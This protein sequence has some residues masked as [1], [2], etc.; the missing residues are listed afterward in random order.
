M[1]ILRLIGSWFLLAALF[2]LVYD[3]TKSMANP[4]QWVIT[5]YY[6]HWNAIHPT[7]LEAARLATETSLHPYVWSPLLTGLMSLPGWLFLG[8]IGVLLFYLGRKRV[9]LNIY[10]N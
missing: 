4:E 3:G 8:G 7:S 10:T 9:N 2:A 5:S 6:D 1:F